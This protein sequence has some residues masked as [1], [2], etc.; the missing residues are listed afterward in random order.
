M[1][2]I[3]TRV[4]THELRGVYG[5]RGALRSE[6]YDVTREGGLQGMALRGRG[7]KKGW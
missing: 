1:S 7:K 6:R 2:S 4:L 5:A 3:A